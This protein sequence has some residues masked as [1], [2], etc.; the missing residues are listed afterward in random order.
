MSCPFVK[1]STFQGLQ[2]VQSLQT[3]EKLVRAT[4]DRAALLVHIT[5]HVLVHH[6]G[7]ADLQLVHDVQ[8]EINRECQSDL[9]RSDLFLPEIVRANSFSESIKQS[10]PGGVSWLTWVAMGG[11]VTGAFLADAMSFVFKE[12]VHLQQLEAQGVVLHSFEKRC[13][14]SGVPNLVPPMVVDKSNQN[15][16]TRRESVRPRDRIAALKFDT[17]SKPDMTLLRSVPWN[18]VG[19]LENEARLRLHL[20]TV[21]KGWTTVQSG[22]RCWGAYMQ[23]MRP[24]SPH[25]PVKANS[26]GA[27]CC[28]FD[29]PGTLSQYMSAVRK[30]HTLLGLNFLSESEVAALKRGSAKFQAKSTKSFVSYKDT[31]KLCVRMVQN[32]QSALARLLAVSYTFQLRT[33]SEG[34]PLEAIPRDVVPG[35]R[36]KWHSFVRV[37]QRSAEIVL[38]SRKNRDVVS[39]IRRD[40]QCPNTPQCCGV[41]ALKQQVSLAREKGESKVFWSVKS[42]D[43]A[44]VQEAARDLALARPTWHGFRRGRTTDLVTCVHWNMS[45]TLLDVFESGG[46]SVGSRAVLHY[47]SEFAKDRERLVSAFSA[48]SDSD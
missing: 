5:D 45:V 23:L 18:Y 3:K 25:F 1:L 41:C 8:V 37:S 7:I 42:G 20:A 21:P 16:G 27:W 9:A 30:A 22:I 32:G 15:F 39:A 31:S 28:L 13:W 19:V 29:N 34:I 35:R 14:S 44:L 17:K 36:E 48:G 43:I 26:F 24:L 11:E 47:L 6:L 40:C 12:S 33:Q 4:L 2:V 38:K 10:L 46:W